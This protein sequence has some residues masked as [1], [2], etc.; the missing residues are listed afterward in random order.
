MFTGP[1][2]NSRSLRKIHSPHGP[3]VQCISLSLSEVKPCQGFKYPVFVWR[4]LRKWIVRKQTCQ[5]RRFAEGN[6]R[7][8]DIWSL[9]Q[10]LSTLLLPPPPELSSLPF[11]LPKQTS[12]RT[13]TLNEW[14]H[15]SVG[16]QEAKLKT[17]IKSQTYVHHCL[18]TWRQQQPL[19][20]L[21]HRST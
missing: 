18:K 1:K 17:A 2:N 19:S 14:D 6:K 4:W 11:V 5:R 21:K 10:Y 12:K 3:V 8:L 20:A 9:F 7:E 13:C 16:L 15:V